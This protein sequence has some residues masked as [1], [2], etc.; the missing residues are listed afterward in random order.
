[1]L[2]ARLLVSATRKFQHCLFG[3]NGTHLGLAGSGMGTQQLLQFLKVPFCI[4]T[5]L[6]AEFVRNLCLF[7]V[8]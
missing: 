3:Y 5:S 2:V 4:K 7:L 8:K 6:D 1:M